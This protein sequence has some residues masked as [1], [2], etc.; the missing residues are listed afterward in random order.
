MPKYQSY[1]FSFFDKN[2]PLTYPEE[3]APLV[4]VELRRPVGAE[5]QHEEGDA[6]DGV[7]KVE[8][9]EEAD[10]GERHA[11]ELQALVVLAEGGL[12]EKKNQSWLRSIFG[13][14]KGEIFFSVQYIGICLL[15]LQWENVSNVRDE[16][17]LRSPR[18]TRKKGG[19]GEDEAAFSF[20]NDDFYRFCIQGPLFDGRRQ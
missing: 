16:C 8:D 3:L 1:F 2:S 9:G 11:Q 18:M 19:R 20:H 4:L 17:T 5:R 12:A 6:E 7:D 14:D 15:T 10:H 13:T